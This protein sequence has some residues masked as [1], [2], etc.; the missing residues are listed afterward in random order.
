MG[1]DLMR[2]TLAYLM[3]LGLI[4]AGGYAHGLWTGRWSNSHDVADDAVRLSHVPETVG[5]W[6]GEPLKLEDEAEVMKAAQIDSY[7]YRKYVDTVNGSVVTMLLVCGRPGPIAVHTPDICFTGSGFTLKADPVKISERVEAIASPVEFWMGDFQKA[8]ASDVQ[9]LRVY[10]SWSTGEGWRAPDNPR[11]HF[12]GKPILYKMYVT[13]SPRNTPSTEEKN[14][15][16]EFLRVMLPAL[17]KVLAPDAG[18]GGPS[19]PGQPARA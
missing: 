12:A 15:P 11:W 19:P 4:L 3:A 16:V 9:A 2:R 18:P 14:P 5:T 1:A 13:C 17:Q 8:T 6:R 7:V 10:W